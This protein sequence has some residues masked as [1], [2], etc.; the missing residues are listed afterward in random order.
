[1]VVSSS[2][3]ADPCAQIS[4]ISFVNIRMSRF[5]A[6]STGSRCIY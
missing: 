3:N 1:L 2:I 5:L 4:E 6:L